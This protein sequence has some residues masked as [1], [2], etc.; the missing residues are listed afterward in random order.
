MPQ[1]DSVTFFAQVFWILIIF[2]LFYLITLEHSL[3]A[4]TAILKTRIK[5]FAANT[6]RGEDAL[7]FDRESLSNKEKEILK[8]SEASINQTVTNAIKGPQW[9]ENFVKSTKE[10]TFAA[11]K[12]LKVNASFLPKTNKALGISYLNF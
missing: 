7:A 11:S 9:T 6:Q 2:G 4:I 10:N 5:N 3:P 1:L 12:N 8:A